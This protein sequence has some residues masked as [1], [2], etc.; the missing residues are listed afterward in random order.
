M[1]EGIRHCNRKA[2][3]RRLEGG[4]PKPAPI[5]TD[6]TCSRVQRNAAA[7]RIFRLQIRDLTFT[8]VV[9]QS[10]EVAGSGMQGKVVTRSCTHAWVGWF[11]GKSRPLQCIGYSVV[12]HVA[13]GEQLKRQ[14]LSLS[15][16]PPPHLCRAA[17]HAMWSVSGRRH[18]REESP[19][20]EATQRQKNGR[21]TAAN[22]RRLRSPQASSVRRRRRAPTP[23]PSLS[24]YPPRPRPRPL[25]QA[26]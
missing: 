12:A 25:P 16:P 11:C 9:A 8:H 4:S 20:T 17:R 23:L 26:H 10:S 22:K 19:S 5:W 3:A 6:G 18:Q 21:E 1:F 7:S 2:A 13:R 15:R 24:P 14:P